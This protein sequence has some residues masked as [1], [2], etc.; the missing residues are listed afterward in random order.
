MTGVDSRGLEWTPGDSIHV[1]NSLCRN[2]LRWKSYTITTLEIGAEMGSIPDVPPSKPTFTIQ[3][4]ITSFAL[5]RNPS[6]SRSNQ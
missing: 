5:D 2:L 4:I 6:A 3:R 1:C